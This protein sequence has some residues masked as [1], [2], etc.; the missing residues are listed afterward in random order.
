MER[1]R[2]NKIHDIKINILC[3]GQFISK[4]LF[5]K[6]FSKLDEIKKYALN[7]LS[8]EYKGNGRRIEIIVHNLDT[9]QIKYINTFS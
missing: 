6:G 8:W 7:C 9:E 1:F 5:I 3:K 4:T 2:I